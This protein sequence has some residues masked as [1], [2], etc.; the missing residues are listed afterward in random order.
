MFGKGD[1]KNGSTFSPVR[2][3][4]ISQIATLGFAVWFMFNSL[5]MSCLMSGSF[6]EA[7]INAHTT[8]SILLLA[9]ILYERRFKFIAIPA[10]SW[11]AVGALVGMSIH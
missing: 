3:A 10:L 2:V 5:R 11:I 7:V 6:G 4:I 8:T 1:M 9:A